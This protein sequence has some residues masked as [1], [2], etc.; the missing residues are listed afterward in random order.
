MASFCWSRR[1]GGAGA[2]FVSG[3]SGL[4]A[5]GRGSLLLNPFCQEKTFNKSFIIAEL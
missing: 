5:A 4:G 2:L 1:Q 3:F